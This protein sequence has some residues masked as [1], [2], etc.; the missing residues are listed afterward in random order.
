MC[1]YDMDLSEGENNKGK[2]LCRSM[3]PF[4]NF[5]Y[6][7][8]VFQIDKGCMARFGYYFDTND[9]IELA[10]T[11]Q[12]MND[13]GC[14]DI[15]RDTMDYEKL[16]PRWQQTV[17]KLKKGDVLVVYKLSNALRGAR[18]LLFFLE[19]CRIRNIRII[20]VADRIDTDERLF[21]D[22]ANMTAHIFDVLANFTFEVTALKNKVSANNRMNKKKLAMR[23]VGTSKLERNANIINLYKSGYPIEQIW[24]LSGF[25][26]RSSVF[27]ILNDAGIKLQRGNGRKKN[28]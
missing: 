28:N 8:P 2:E 21:T 25:R 9:Q 3:M 12:W 20:S 1:P 27:R 24:K 11:I 13:F 5:S 4:R 18:E 10:R 15:V 16:R 23:K 19:F 14:E 26:S 17:E 22:I 6:L 7:C